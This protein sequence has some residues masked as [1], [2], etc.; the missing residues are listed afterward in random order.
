MMAL[1]TNQMKN[2]NL[3][4]YLYMAIPV[5][6]PAIYF[7]TMNDVAALIVFY[8][9]A[10]ICVIFDQKEIVKAGNESKPQF[11]GSA[12]G[13]LIFP[14]LYVYGRAKTADLKMS[15]HFRCTL[16]PNSA[17]KNNIPG[18][19]SDRPGRFSL[20]INVTLLIN[21]ILR[22]LTRKPPEGQ[23]PYVTKNLLA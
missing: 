3:Y 13:I 6:F 5:L 7:F 23:L 10:I 22:R 18:T 15:T 8:V 19:M 9:A 20:L 12:L 14:P 16:L 1:T 21:K 17:Q 11:V 4:F 2:N